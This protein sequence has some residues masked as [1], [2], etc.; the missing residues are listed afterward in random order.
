MILL[1]PVHHRWIPRDIIGRNSALDLV[2]TVSG[3]NHDPEDWIPDVPSFLVWTEISGVLGTREKNEAARLA[4]V[5][6]PAAE[7]V[8]ASAKELRFALW[9]LISSLQHRKTAKPRDLSVIDEWM[10]RLALSRHA[11]VNRN[12]VN[13]AINRDISVLDI[14]SLRVIAAARTLLEHFPAARIK[15]CAARDCGW[16]FLDF[17]K[18]RSRRW[19]DMAVCGNLAKARHYRAR[20]SRQSAKL[21]LIQQSDCKQP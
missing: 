13:F 4:A 12:I 18:N 10:H 21:E 17:S 20:A 8:L 15:T 16:K 2:N 7:R 3:W 9:S 11:V 5:S 19:C 6:H 14:P 1:R